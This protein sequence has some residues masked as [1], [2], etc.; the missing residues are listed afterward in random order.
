MISAHDLEFFQVLN[1]KANLQDITEA[2]NCKADMRYVQNVLADKVEAKHITQHT[3]SLDNFQEQLAHKC[4]SKEFDD[5]TQKVASLLQDLTN[6]IRLK[7]NMSDVVEFLDAKSNHNE[8]ARAFA[9]LQKEL[10]RKAN[11]EELR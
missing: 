1:K 4:S 7:A 5:F 2:L 6:E 3:R 9:D 8:V 11:M 10:M